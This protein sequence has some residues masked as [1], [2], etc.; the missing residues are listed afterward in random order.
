MLLCTRQNNVV[1]EFE[2]GKHLTFVQ[3]VSAYIKSLT[4]KK[5]R[6]NHMKHIQDQ[7]LKRNCPGSIHGH[8]MAVVH[9]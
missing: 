8:A 5:I 9:C 6:C 2:L 3:F 1:L 4:N 7:P